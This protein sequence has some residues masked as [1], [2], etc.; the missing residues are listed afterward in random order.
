MESKLWY[1]KRCRLFDQLTP[2][3]ARRLERRA[4]VRLYKKQAFIYSPVELAETVLVLASG[5]VKILGLTPEGKETILAFIDEGELFGELAL[6]DSDPRE[7]YAEAVQ[8]SKVLAIPREDM[9]WLM[10]Q[11]PDVSLSITKLVGL[12]RKRIENRLRNLLFLPSRDRMVRILQE[13]VESHGKREKERCTIQLPLSHQDLA[14]LIGVT[15]ETVTLVL[16]QLQQER[17]IEINRRRIVVRDCDRLAEEAT[18]VAKS[19]SGKREPIHRTDGAS[20]VQ[21][22]SQKTH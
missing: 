16:G 13:L 4:L 17:L 2:R 14:G 19:S 9:L 3:E 1:L 6:V 21:R 10:G 7:E 20:V 22:P 8:D 15:R 11:R 5:R 18:G 12:R